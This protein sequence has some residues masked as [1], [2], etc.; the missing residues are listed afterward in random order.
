[1]SDFN[2]RYCLYL[3]SPLLCFR[4]I[5]KV[6]LKTL[7]IYRI[8]WSVW[9]S[10]TSLVRSADDEV[11]S[12]ETRVSKMEYNLTEAIKMEIALKMARLNPQHIDVTQPQYP[13]WNAV[14][15]QRSKLTD[16]QGHCSASV[17]GVGT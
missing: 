16:S 1:M 13:A 8:E 4:S 15:Y 2:I 9:N 5:I 17:F 12:L 14:C 7:I 3:L 6:Y 10:H 11:M